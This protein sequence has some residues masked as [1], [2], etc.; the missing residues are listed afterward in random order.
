M[1]EIIWRHFS[2]YGTIEDITIKPAKGWA[3]IRFA[4][5]CMA[6][7]AKECM[8]NQELDNKEM[9]LVRWA[10]DDDKNP[11]EVERRRKED[12]KLVKDAIEKKE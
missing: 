6:E 11:I 3:F 12:L 1:Y 7:F 2:I 10:A 9:I 8:M 5:R 4:H